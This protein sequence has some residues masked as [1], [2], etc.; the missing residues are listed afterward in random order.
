MTEVDY[1]EV[2]EVSREASGAELKKSYRKLAMKYHPDRNPDDKEAEEKFKQINEAYQVLS[3]DEKRA[4]YDLQHPAA[5]RYGVRVIGPFQFNPVSARSNN[6]LIR[7]RR[8]LRRIW[9]LWTDQTRSGTKIC[10]GL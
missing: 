10:T 3:D 4:I 8:R 9:W 7:R 5:L 1:Y 6:E 2:L